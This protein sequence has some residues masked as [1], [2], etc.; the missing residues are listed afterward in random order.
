MNII[1]DSLAKKYGEMSPNDKIYEK[2]DLE[3]DII[4]CTA[5][6]VLCDYLKRKI[7]VANAGDSRS[8]MGHGGRCTPLSFDHKPNV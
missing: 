1:A 2:D 5:N 4:G 8:V 6:V 3:L 7:F